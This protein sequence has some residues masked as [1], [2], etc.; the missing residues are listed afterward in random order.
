[1][2]SRAA[3]IA[4]TATIWTVCSGSPLGAEEV[5]RDVPVRVG[6]LQDM[7]VEAVAVND[8]VYRIEGEGAFFL[9]NTSEGSVLVDTGT[10]Y[11]QNE[12]Q[13]AKVREL[14]TGP[15]RKVIVTHAL[16]VC[17]VLSRRLMPGKSSSSRTIDTGTCRD[18]RT[19]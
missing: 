12:E 17:P 16:A 7:G 4:I 14:A 11:A 3:A 19:S 18:C 15:I 2:T 10:P 6:D 5:E 13:M 8:F 1:M 9:I